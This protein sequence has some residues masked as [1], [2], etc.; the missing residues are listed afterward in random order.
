MEVCSSAQR[1]KKLTVV[2]VSRQSGSGGHI[3]AQQVAQKLGFYF[4]D[5]EITQAVGGNAPM[6]TLLVE[7]SDEKGISAIDG[8]ILPVVRKHHLWGYEYMQ[9][10]W[11]GANF[12]LP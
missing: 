12:I 9:H 2:A 10:Y 5:Q 3:L 6:K 11:A 1:R 4:F 7:S 8:I